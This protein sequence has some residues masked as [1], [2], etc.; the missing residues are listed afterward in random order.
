MLSDAELGKQADVLVLRADTPNLAPL[1]NPIAAVVHA[2]GIHNVDA[3]YV[4]GR[5]VK[6][7]GVFVDLDVA[8]VL[9]RATASHEYL[10]K[11]ASLRP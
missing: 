7:N 2:A 3:V 8:A 4:A 10:I 5:P 11:A 9:L 1:S 6:Q